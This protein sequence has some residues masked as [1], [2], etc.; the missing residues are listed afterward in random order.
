MINL[1]LLEADFNDNDNDTDLVYYSRLSNIAQNNVSNIRNTI[2]GLIKFLKDNYNFIFGELNDDL[3]ENEE[4]SEIFSEYL[5]D[6]YLH[7][8]WIG[9]SNYYYIRDDLSTNNDSFIN[10]F[11]YELQDV[12]KD[13]FDLSLILNTIDYTYLTYDDIYE[14]LI[15]SKLNPNKIDEMIKDNVLADNYYDSTEQIILDFETGINDLYK[16]I[17][18]CVKD[19][20]YELSDIMNAYKFYYSD[21]S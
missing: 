10:S 15:N 14:D 1:K 19:I 18:L 9:R 6:N 4:S 16:D 17:K 5:E 13:K 8:E 3:L 12:S 20:K 2:N 7:R 11:L 21:L